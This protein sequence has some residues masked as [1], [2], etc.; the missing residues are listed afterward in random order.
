MACGCALVTTDSLGVREYA[1]HEKTALIS[2]PKNPEKL[3]HNIIRMLR[4]N[5]L[6][7]SLA[8]SGHKFIKNFTW[9]KAVN[10]FEKVL[11][12]QK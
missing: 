11:L 2:E 6:R 5:D 9:E 7:I 3:S 8:E 1:L 4:D 10:E 12:N